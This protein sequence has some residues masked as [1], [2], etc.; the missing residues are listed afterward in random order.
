MRS[1]RTVLLCLLTAGAFSSAHGQDPVRTAQT[2]SVQKY[3]IEATMPADSSRAVPVKAVLTLKNVSTRPASTLTLRISPSADIT[4]V[5]LN[6]AVSDF[7]KNEEKINS[8]TSLQRIVIRF[9]SIAPGAVA[10]AAVDY[11]VNI[12]DNG[13]LISM[14]PNAAHFLPL[15]FWYPTPNSWF[16]PQGADRAPVRL[17]VNSAGGLAVVSS[18]SETA[19]AFEDKLLSQPFFVSG[20]WDTTNV[21]G[22]SVMMPKGTG[23]EGQKR[24]AEMA[25]LFSDARSFVAGVLG[26]GP[27]APMRIVSSRRG[28]GFGN[29]GTLM[30][31]EAVFRRSKVDSLTAMN[32]AE[33]AAR[34]WLGNYIAISG[35]GYG[36]ISEGLVRYLA[37][38][39]IESKFG[40]D[41]AD[42]ER[43]RQR[44]SYAA[45]S[46]RDAPMANVSP[47]DDFYYPEVANKGAMAWRMVA[48]R[49]GATE[50]AKVL[51][52]NSQ[53]R[54]L[55]LAELRLALVG[56]KP[57]LDHFL[58]Q[59]TDMNL[60]AGLP[61][62]GAGETK[63]NLR[64]TGSTD[65]TVDV[66]ATTE[67]GER[68]TTSATLRPTSFGEV[69]FKTNAE[70]VRVEIDGDKLFP[71]VDYSDDVAPRETTDSDPLLAVKR[72]YDKQEYAKAEALA[73]V[74]LRDLPRFDD[75]RIYLGRS[76]LAQNK[77][78]EADREFRSVLD[79]KLPTSRSLA[80]GNVGLAD[81]A[82]RSGQNDAAIKYA[83]TAISADAE[84]GAS[85][86]AR[87]VRSKAGFTSPVDQAVKEF[88]AAFD[89]AA[90]SNRRTEVES[91]V[92]PGEVTKFA[93]GVA[94]ST[95][96]WQT[97]IRAVD[98]IDANTLLVEANMTIKLL[99]KEAES[100][101]A[102]Y[103]LTRT[104]NSWK[105][106]AVE[107]FEVR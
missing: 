84:Y 27:D 92:L 48:K 39:F 38:Q 35:E 47:I 33:T 29:G 44:N 93:S 77:L 89:K 5:R 6:E 73:R 86:A 25:A 8:A 61:V 79:E 72:S 63:V 55:D 68:L 58:D 40:K 20:N 88:F 54:S 76:L 26:N 21:N 97:Q 80:W 85:L 12:K 15:S 50:F 51:T 43:L 14:A 16:F 45:V 102:V 67:S 11:K 100:G 59:V 99:N 46:K 31:D 10:T 94:G 4:A 7:S 56:Q 28:A 41:V 71:Q 34:L 98:K 18:G 23:P 90:A 60:L 74:L 30:V 42:I 36:V 32:I 82:Q 9:G 49:L 17:K 105:L 78:A 107:M 3:D 66:V 19:G 106:S 22:V 87:N 69:V 65:V 103:R 81:G 37:T 62:A 95:E 2:W 75:L 13:G 96:Q 101:I 64:N 70:V 83:E 53:D 52:Q 104:G 57:L 24:G 1:I 91:F